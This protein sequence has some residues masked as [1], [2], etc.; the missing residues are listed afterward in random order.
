MKL[1]SVLQSA[2]V[3]IGIASAAQAELATSAQATLATYGTVAKGVGSVVFDPAD[4]HFANVKPIADAN[5]ATVMFH[6]IGYTGTNTL[7]A[8]ELSMASDWSAIKPTKGGYFY[9]AA[10]TTRINGWDMQETNGTSLDITNI[11]P[12]ADSTKIMM[13]Y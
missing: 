5:L 4:I 11:K 13:A 9:E 1:K 10:A 2:L 12:I 7:S 6:D 8:Q 3:A